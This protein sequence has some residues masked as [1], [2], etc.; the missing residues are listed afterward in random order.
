MDGAPEL[1]QV[2][3]EPIAPAP[4]APSAPSPPPTA[5]VAGARNVAGGDAAIVCKECGAKNRPTEWYC[6]KCGAE[7]TAF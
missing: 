7:L 5:P 3:L 4:S 2:P 6:E 1:I